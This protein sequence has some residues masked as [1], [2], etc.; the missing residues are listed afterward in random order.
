M[1][2]K[3]D[4]NLLDLLAG[5]VD[6]APSPTLKSAEFDKGLSKKKSDEEQAQLQAFLANTPMDTLSQAIAKH[7]MEMKSAGEDPRASINDFFSSLIART[8]ESILQAE[9]DAHIGFR[10]YQHSDS[11]SE[12]VSDG[13]PSSQSVQSTGSVDAD[14]GSP[15][16]STAEAS[17]E[18]KAGRK[19]NYR[20][21]SYPRTIKTAEGEL[22]I[23]FPRDREGSFESIILPKGCKDITG[24]QD[25]ILTLAALGSST[26]EVAEIIKALLKVE[27]SHEY[28]HSVIEGYV[29]RVKDW[30]MRSLKDQ[31]FPFLFMDCIYLPVRNAAGVAEQRPL[32]VILGIDQD[33]HKDILD[34]EIIGNNESVRG[35]EFML[36]R[37]VK[38][39]LKDPLFMCSDGI[40]GLGKLC[41][42]LFP[43][44]I[45]QRCIVHFVRNLRDLVPSKDR[46]DFIKDFKAVYNAAD[47]QSSQ[48]ALKA[49]VDKW[50]DKARLATNKVKQEYGT[51]IAP[52]FDLPF[53]VRKVVYTTNAIE[54]VNSSLRKVINKGCFKDTGSIEAL[55]LLRIERVLSKR[56]SRQIANW[57]RVLQGLLECEKTKAIVSKHTGL[58]AF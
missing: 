42:A 30:K 9:M 53:A 58:P 2:P 55:L 45:H 32:Y 25:K 54:A 21:G 15:C 26:R 17:S 24:M 49:F 1:K 44:A 6:A 56:W 20:N 43:S 8:V 14:N 41:K 12:A 22:H 28:V 48:E 46:P 5:Q 47:L 37:L 52:L 29:S 18:Q 16:Q 4:P 7:L 34:F 50:Q 35:W 51:I 36:D 33:G 38:R 13:D 57:P 40:V 3:I 19:R 39:G 10:R 11:E 27:V 23:N 31:H